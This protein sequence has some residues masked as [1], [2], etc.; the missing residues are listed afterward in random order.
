MATLKANVCSACAMST[1]IITMMPLTSDRLG[2]YNG[3]RSGMNAMLAGNDA[4]SPIV[5][6]ITT[7][8]TTTCLGS[9]PSIGQVMRQRVRL[10]SRILDQTFEWLA[11][12]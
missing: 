10:L 1:L 11:L 6:E 8:S 12:H 7:Q 4:R 5:H 9:L 2:W 3:I